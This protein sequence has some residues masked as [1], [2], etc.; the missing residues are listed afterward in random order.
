M[1]YKSLVTALAASL[2]LVAGANVQAHQFWYETADG[3]LTF[4]Y[5]ELDVNML[6][7]SPGG[8]DRIVKL[9][10]TL[11][12]PAGEKKFDLVKR[13]DRLD[14]PAGIKPAASDSLV[15]VDLH[16]PMHDMVHNGKTVHNYW[17][18]ANRWVGDF[19]EREP[20]LT[21]DMVPTGVSS[22]DSVQVKVTYLGEAL[23]GEAIKVSVPSG[24]VRTYITDAEGLIDVATPW[25]G[26]Y[27]VNLYYIDEVEGVRKLDGV[28]EEAYQ[29][30]GYNTTLSFERSSGLEPLPVA[31]KTY[32]A[33]Y[34][35][36]QGLEAP[37]HR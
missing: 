37:K 17:I 3:A 4:R 14:L 2:L 36:D 12:T 22:D 8:M 23:A 25:K 16:Y 34:Y 6:E 35:R 24:W 19:R 9:Q 20:V 18:P 15:S 5:G 29:T 21:L 26:L 30:E 32:P 33:S 10:T 31:P 7:V 1:K 11:Y 28:P 27:S 13:P